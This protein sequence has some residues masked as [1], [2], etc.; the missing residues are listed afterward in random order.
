MGSAGPNRD[1]FI[2]SRCMVAS[3]PGSA[4]GSSAPAL[5]LVLVPAQPVPCQP[6]LAVAAPTLS[7][8]L[9]W[10]A[11]ALGCSWTPLPAP[12]PEEPHEGESCSFSAIY[13]LPVACSSNSPR[14]ASSPEDQGAAWG[15]VELG[16]HILGCRL[17]AVGQGWCL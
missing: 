5:I 13:T 17:A 2:P 6:T 16:R 7:T 4:S 11:A 14:C 12:S 1:G 3:S 10:V 9:S 15:L 8:V